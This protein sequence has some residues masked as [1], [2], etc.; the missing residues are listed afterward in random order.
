MLPSGDISISEMSKMLQVI[1]QFL[2]DIQARCPAVRD[3]CSGGFFQYEIFNI[4][5]PVICSADIVS[6][7]TELNSKN[8]ALTFDSE[9]AGAHPS[10]ESSSIRTSSAASSPPNILSHFEN[11]LKTSPSHTGSSFI[12]ITSESA[13]ITSSAA[14]FVPAVSPSLV[15]G[16]SLNTS[17]LT[18]PTV[19]GLLEMVAALFAHMV[20][21]RKDFSGLN[22]LTKVDIIFQHICLSW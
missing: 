8:S 14:R 13:S 2:S 4:L 6:A 20:L 1:T 15:A 10:N 3:F 12:L 16:R 7:E 11:K 17:S 22:L 9:H 18:N 21:E 19:Q 5:F